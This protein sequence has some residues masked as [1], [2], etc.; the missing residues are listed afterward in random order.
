MSLINKV[1]GVDIAV[2][3]S[4]YRFKIVM[5]LSLHL[6]QEVSHK[7]LGKADVHKE[8]CPNSN[9]CFVLHDS[10]GFE[11]GQEGE[12]L[13]VQIFIRQRSKLP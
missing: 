2:R 10:L 13:K 5:M 4:Y 1:F 11:P 9:A 3:F 7:E 12:F 6:P 8:L